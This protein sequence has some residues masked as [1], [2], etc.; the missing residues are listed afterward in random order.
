MIEKARIEKNL[1]KYAFPRL[2]GTVFELMAFNQVKE[3]IRNLKLD[4]EV[5]KF[6]FS[7][8][9]SR[10]YPKIAFSFTS[11]IFFLLYLNIF[12]SSF[13]VLILILLTLIIASIVLTRKPEKIQFIKQSNSQNLLVKIKPRSYNNRNKDRIIIF[14]SHLDSKGQRFKIKTRIKIIKFWISSSLILA[15]VIILKNWILNGFELFLYCLGLIPLIANIFAFILL[16]LNKTD[17]TSKGA[18]DN[19]SG[20]TCNLEL[21]TFYSIPEN[22]LDNY[23]LWFL[24]TG[25]EECGTMGIKYFYNNLENFDP[26][27]S[28]VFNFESIAR[29]VYLFPGGNEGV[30]ARNIDSLLLNNQRDLPIRHFITDRVFGTHSDGGF[31]GDKGFQGYGIGEVEAYDYMHTPQDTIDKIDT[32]I[33]EKV[34]LVLTD[35]LKE[36]DTQFF[37]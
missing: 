24:F 27:K 22:R 3:E 15:T 35:A 29:H 25:A 8:F 10:I 17:N 21:V 6:T 26:K 7:S 5:Q 30:H 9:Y 1:K 19:A 31:L 12:M 4:F 2:S 13:S 20:I 32:K 37:K 18:V 14:I 23:H 28:V 11:L 33:L 34:C 16:L 36:H